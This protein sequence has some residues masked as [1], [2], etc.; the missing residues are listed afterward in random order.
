MYKLARFS[1]ESQSFSR[2]LQ[3]IAKENFCDF[4]YEF[5]FFFFFG[6]SLPPSNMKI[7]ANF[8]CVCVNRKL[9]SSVYYL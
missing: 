1:Y 9:S 5:F 7:L 4:R 2:Y 8:V 6:L 3:S